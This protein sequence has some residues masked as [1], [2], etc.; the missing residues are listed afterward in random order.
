MIV[1]LGDILRKSRTQA[2]YN[3]ADEGNE[4]WRKKSKKRKREKD[5]SIT[6]SL[7][8]VKNAR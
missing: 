4:R 1:R 2:P 6:A 7:H 3:R 8:S 5:I